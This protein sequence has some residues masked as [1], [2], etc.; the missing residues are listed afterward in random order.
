MKTTATKAELSFI[1]KNY[2]KLPIKTIAKD[3]GRS[4]TFVRGRMKALGLVIPAEIA[5]QRK[6]DS[7]IKVGTVPK[8]KGKK[9]PV[10]IY[11]KVCHTFFKKGH[12]PHNTAKKDG[13]IS[14]RSERNIYGKREYKYI[15]ISR[16]VWV[17]YHRYRWELFRGPLPKGYCLSFKNGDTLDCRISNLELIS[18]AQNA[19]RNKAKFN[20]LPLPL[21]QTKRLINKITDKIKQHEK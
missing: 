20:A 8:N 10:E 14:I 4:Q 18:R 3:L 17:P 5:E 2:L 15:R 1:R 9:M 6:R 11:E 7:W 19:I 16:S 12:S 21:Q 13:V